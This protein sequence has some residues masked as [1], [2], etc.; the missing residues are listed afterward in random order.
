MLLLDHGPALLKMILKSLIMRIV[1]EKKSA[2]VAL[3][4]QLISVLDR[5]LSLIAKES[6]MKTTSLFRAR[7]LTIAVSQF[8][9][10][11]LALIIPSQICRLVSSYFESLIEGSS[12][13]KSDQ[14]ELRLLV[15]QELVSF[16]YQV[17]LNFSS[18]SDEPLSLR[19]QRESATHRRWLT[20]SESALILNESVRAI[21]NQNSLNDPPSH[22]FADLFLS[23]CFNG[24]RQ[25]EI[26]IQEKSL[27]LLHEAL[28]R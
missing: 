10:S 14:I 1:R 2:P 27:K 25:V 11:L 17:A 20:T 16:D 23:E 19:R 4:S 3:D 22:W 5:L 12:Y 28:V 6:A 18:P 7:R 24:Y 15:L 26:K 9:R 21:L 13:R 8:L